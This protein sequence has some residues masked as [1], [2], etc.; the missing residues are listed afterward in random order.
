MRRLRRLAGLA[1][2]VIAIAGCAGESALPQATGKG[3]IRA[4][5]AA[6]GSPTV[7]FL[8]EERALDAMAYKSESPGRQWDDFEY[9][10]NF[11]AT[12][13]GDLQPTRIANEL[14]KI[15][16]NRDYTFV[17]SGS[18]TAPSIRIWEADSPDFDEGDTVFQSRLAHLAAGLGDLD[19]YFDA[20]GVAPV[21]GAARGTIGYGEILPPLEA[22]AGEYVL[23]VTAAG[24]PSDIVYQSNTV[25]YGAQTAFV[26]P[27]F[28]GDELEAAPY[29][30]R[31]FN[32]NGGTIVMPDARI[33][34][35]VRLYQASS[36][37]A[38]ADVYSDEG[39]TELVVANHAFGDVTGDLPTVTGDSALY[40]TPAGNTGAIL[41]EGPL[42]VTLA[43]SRNAFVVYGTGTER[44][45]LTYR[46]DRRS[47]STTVRLSA[48]NAASNHE[49]L[50]LYVADAGAGF[51]NAVPRAI[52]PLGF[53]P[54]TI[55]LSPGSHDI[56]LTVGNE[57]TIVTGP[58]GVDV[59]LGD[60]V[61]TVV[62]DVTDPS[63][64]E[65]RILPAP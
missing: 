2:I 40:Y 37:L 49:L 65:F 29:T 36:D 35:T 32:L 47:V 64:A 11:E 57:D 1:A 44:Q 14:V 9:N 41:F 30:A 31:G 23:T 61:E 22:E 19:F 52:L 20:P 25:T 15:E 33:P 48:I 7:A 56:Y 62:F 60:A 6:K 28:E 16:P 50:D 26:I 8:I 12:L 42:Q 46:P 53:P 54:S 17:F 55:Q 13:A 4:I 59:A 51:E 3:T 24:D 63:A 58:V 45:S 34:A 27:L 10:F 39:L 43:G 18:V 5:N 38:A 21:S